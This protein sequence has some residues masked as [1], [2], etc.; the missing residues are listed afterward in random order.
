MN[1][2]IP[3]LHHT[4]ENLDRKLLLALDA[5]PTAS[6]QQLAG[7]LGVSAGTV[8]RRYAALK[9]SG[10]LKITGRTL[11]GFGGHNVW[12]CR[13]AAKPNLLH[14]L[15]QHMAKQPTSRWVR[16]SFDRS[17]LMCG[18]VTTPEHTEPLDVL[19][20]NQHLEFLQVFELFEV[21]SRTPQPT[22]TE[23]DFHLDALDHKILDLLH[24]DGRMEAQAISKKLGVD[25]ST[26]SRRRKRL[27]DSN[28]L[29]FEADISPDAFNSTADVMLWMHV[30]PG[31]ITE[32]GAWLSQLPHCR[33]V[34]ATSGQYSL[35]AHLLLP[36]FGQLLDFIDKDLAP[37]GLAR[38]EIEHMGTTFKRTAGLS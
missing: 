2:D 35:V 18:L 7:E 10:V 34:A 23:A 3:A 5:S 1:P 9:K 6:F 13:A 26:V 19:Q 33:F 32:L 4:F 16:L 17:E 12:L 31:H 28:I 27:I 8:S 24:G 30:N 20:N 36:T 25:A 22:L 38:C 21:W 29:Y 37:R 14:L 15:A 11:P